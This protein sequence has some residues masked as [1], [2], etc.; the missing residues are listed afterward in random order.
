MTEK[1]YETMVEDCERKDLDYATTAMETF[2]AEYVEH[3]WEQG[4]EIF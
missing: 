4:V 3:L 2:E 1:E